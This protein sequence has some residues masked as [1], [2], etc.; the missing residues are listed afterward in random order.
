LVLRLSPPEVRRNPL[1][2]D[3]VMLHPLAGTNAARA[4]I[5]QGAAFL[6]DA[7]HGN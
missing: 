6:R 5:A 3:F 1:I 2:H 4:A 7:L